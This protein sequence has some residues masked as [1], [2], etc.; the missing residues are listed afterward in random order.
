MR[1]VTRDAFERIVKVMVDG[2]TAA[3]LL[4]GVY[5]DLTARW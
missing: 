1:H 2:T 4:D 3:G 5:L